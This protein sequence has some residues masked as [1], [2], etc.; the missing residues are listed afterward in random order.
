[1]IDQS[2]VDKILETANVVDIIQDYITLKKR[3]VNYIGLCPFHHEK[4]PSF[5]VSP[6]KGIYKCFGCGKGGNSV[7][8]IMEH[9]HISYV[10]ALKLLARR[11]HIDFV[12]KEM[13]ADEISQKTERDSLLI[14]TSFAQKYFT[15][16]LLHHKEGIAIGLTYFKERGFQKQTI[17]NFQ[18]GYCTD[19]R[20]GFTQSAIN[21]GFK[22]DYLIKTGLTLEN[23]HWDRF[24]GRVIFPIHDLSG[25]VIAYGGRTLK[26]DKKTAKY[27]NSPESEIY[28][29]SK[30]LYGIYQAKKSIVQ[31]DKCYLVEGYT[32]VISLHQA[33]IE[34]VVASSGTSLTTD[35]IRLIKRFTTNVT[36]LYDGD[37]AGIKAS[38]RGIDMVLEEGLNV[39][40]L[41]FPDNEDPDSFSKRVSST[42]LKEFISNNEQD[43]ISFKT[44]LLLQDTKN[45]PVSKANLISD[46]VRSISIIPDSIIRS[47]YIKECSTLLKIE[48]RVLYSEINKIRRQKADH[49]YDQLKYP[50]QN[51][52]TVQPNVEEYNQVDLC[53][54]QEREIIRLLL[55]YANIDLYR[56]KNEDTG[57]EQIIKLAAHI[58]ADIRNDELDFINPLYRQLFEE[59]EHF[60]FEN[61]VPDNKYFTNHSDPEIAGLA[62]DLLTSTYTLSKIFEKREAYIETEEMKIQEVVEITIV[63]FK[64]KKILME[65]S[66][67][68][69]S[70]K[71]CTDPEELLSLLERHIKLKE[72]NKNLSKGLGGI[73]II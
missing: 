45:D 68:E 54:P 73:A 56:T 58:I 47:V 66:N 36:I 71:S 27:V 37:A 61:N 40:V 4:S 60:V 35:Q 38:L 25:K 43:F 7:N 3:G 23:P 8:F 59:Y 34:N 51:I 39:R 6:S 42:E 63:S 32:D 17:D 65:I 28:H 26:T 15:E 46:I 57:E 67:I 52:N 53:E 21:S 50:N 72:I 19:D 2:T 5:T 22:I 16:T 1:M 33:G 70:I 31:Q 13:T 64:M 55:H 30:V 44:K 10:E 69:D 12:E 24:S 62:V 9:E 18:L 11:Y 41:L 49:K 20:D 14:I 48:E 29:K